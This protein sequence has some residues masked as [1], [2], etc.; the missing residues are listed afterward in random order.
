MQLYRSFGRSISRHLVREEIRVPDCK[1]RRRTR[2]HSYVANDDR[3]YWPML[4][5]PK[6]FHLHRQHAP[7]ASDLHRRCQ[8]EPRT[9]MTAR[10]PTPSLLRE[11]LGLPDPPIPK[12]QAKRE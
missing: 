10:N 6:S 11:S 2:V 9:N 5:T 8:L 12:K 3:S 1:A 4:S 7:V